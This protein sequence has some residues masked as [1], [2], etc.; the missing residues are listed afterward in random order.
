MRENA[1]GFMDLSSCT[2][3]VRELG[4]SASCAKLLEDNS[5]LVGGWDGRIKYWTDQGDLIWET[6][7]PNRVSSLE[8]TN[9]FLFSTSGLD[10][11]CIELKTGQH[12]WSVPL[13]GSADAVIATETC[14]LAVSSVYDIEHNDFLESAI[15]AISFEGDI[16]ETHRM[17]ERPWTLQT[18]NG[19][20]IAGLGRPRNG[21]ITLDDF[22][23]ILEQN[24]N[25]EYPTICATNLN[26]PVFGLADG[27]VRSMSG[28][29]MRTM[30]SAIC[31]LEAH[32]Q[33]FLIAD[34]EGAVEFFETTVQWTFSGDEVV[35][36]SAGF[37]VKGTSTCWIA[38]WNGSQG[39]LAV[40]SIADGQQ[41]AT[42]QGHRVHDI[43]SNKNRV[44]VVCENGQVFVW[45][46]SLFE[47]RM[48]Q[49]NQQENDANRSAMFEK[50]RSLRK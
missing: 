23:H 30:N 17:D 39:E 46:S 42:L 4:E 27:S 21:Y 7:T 43:D 44:V 41:I 35:S 50:L 8:V 48:K 40:R 38:R 14:V 34:D 10:I 20:A 36:L 37:D 45:E 9:D 1:S 24:M 29:V 12:R 32:R 18:F 33:G 16:L 2:W 47:R 11:V 3:M 19:G 49:P 6:K 13:E 25:W 5:L 15:W 31:C 22:G 26:E 28:D